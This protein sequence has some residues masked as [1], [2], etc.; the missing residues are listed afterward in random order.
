MPISACLSLPSSSTTNMGTSWVLTPP[1]VDAPVPWPS[2]G[3]SLLRRETQCWTITSYQH[4]P[5]LAASFP[6]PLVFYDAW[7]RFQLHGAS[8]VDVIIVDWCLSAQY[9]NRTTQPC[10]GLMKLRRIPSSSQITPPLSRPHFNLCNMRFPWRRHDAKESTNTSCVQRWCFM[11]ST[12][13]C[14]PVR[15]MKH[16]RGAHVWFEEHWQPEADGV[17]FTGR[18]FQLKQDALI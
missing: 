9:S 1:S 13:G 11:W 14:N 2:F 12:W 10:H 17:P 15:Y 3:D 16:V 4:R 6:F 5:L 18:L 8:G 7:T